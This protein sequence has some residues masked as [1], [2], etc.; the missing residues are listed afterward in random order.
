MLLKLFRDMTRAEPVFRGF[1]DLASTDIELAKKDH[2]GL[3]LAL[4]LG[5]VVTD[6]M[7]LL[8]GPFDA[9][10]DDHGL[11]FAPN[12][13]FVDHLL[14]EM[15]HH[16]LGFHANGVFMLLHI[17][18]QFLVCLNGIKLRVILHRLR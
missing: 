5:Q 12:L 13:L 1:G 8:E 14:V 15:I 11:G 6:G 4:A 9:I 16:D 2:D 10:A 3:I 17:T 18:P 7:V